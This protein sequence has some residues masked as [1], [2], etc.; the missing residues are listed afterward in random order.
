MGRKRSGSGAGHAPTRAVQVLVDAGVDHRVLSFDVALDAAGERYG[1][2]AAKALGVDP[3]RTFKTLMVALPDGAL[4]A[5]CVPVSGSLDLHAAAAALG[6]KRVAMAELAVAER[7]SG[8]VRG[9]ISPLG[10]RQRHRTVVD[11]SALD[12]DVMYVSAGQRGLDLELDP[13]D[14]IRLAEADVAA[15]AAE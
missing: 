7:R 3:A 8:Y 9:G 5:C 4:A 11:A 1:V 12:G 6:V 10:Q 14:L 15:I 2:Q 13:R